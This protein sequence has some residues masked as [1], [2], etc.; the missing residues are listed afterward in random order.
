MHICACAITAHVLGWVIAVCFTAVK[1]P[2]RYTAQH[3]TPDQGKGRSQGSELVSVTVLVSC[4]H[5]YTQVC[6]V[7]YTCTGAHTGIYCAVV[8]T[9]MDLGMCTVH[10]HC[11][12]C[13]MDVLQLVTDRIG[14]LLCLYT[15]TCIYRCVLCCCMH[16][17]GLSH[18]QCTL[19]TCRCSMDVSH[20]VTNRVGVLQRLYTSTCIYRCVLC[21]CMHTH[22]LRHVQCTYR[23]IHSLRAGAGWVSRSDRHSWCPVG[24]CIHVF[25]GVYCT[26]VYAHYDCVFV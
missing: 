4:R 5:L 9:H 16:T 6:T 23:H 7:V 1:P 3:Y 20:L 8:C 15:S 10:V 21:S 25:T 24:I 14:A 2:Y 13:S 22:G 11:L 18:V 12:R 17:H 26:V 19:F